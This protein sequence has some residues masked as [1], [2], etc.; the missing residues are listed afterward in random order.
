M[1]IALTIIA[2]IF[3]A[4][5]LAGV[6]AGLTPPYVRAILRRSSAPKTRRDLALEILGWLALIAWHCYRYPQFLWWF[7][8]SGVCMLGLTVA[9]WRSAATSSQS[10]T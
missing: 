8:A 6:V 3:A 2:G 9:A 4:F 5:A 1:N 10:R 7:V